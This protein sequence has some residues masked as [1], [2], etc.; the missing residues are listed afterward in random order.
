MK[1]K[2]LLL[3]SCALLLCGCGKIPTLSNGDE[4]VVTFK[5][6]A[7]ISANAL[8][9]EIKDNYGL[10]TLISMIDEYIYEKEFSDKMSD[11]EA[12]AKAVVSQ[13][14]SNYDDEASALQILQSYYGYSTF[15]AYQK[16]VYMNYLQSE[17]ITAYVKN[18]ITE[19]EL[20]EYYENDVYPSMTISHILVT[21]NVSSS[22][23]DD[24]KTEAE[25]AAKEKVK[26][27][28]S[29]LDTAKSEGKDIAEA[30]GSLAKEYSEDAESKNSN[31]ELGEINIGSLNSQY[32]ELVKAAAKLNDGEY[33]TDVITTELGYHVILKTK[34]GEK[35]SYEDSL[36]SMKDK[37]ADTKL[38]ASNSQ[39]LK[40]EAVKAYR[41]DYEL[42]IVDSELNSQYGKYM[43][44]L[45]NSAKSN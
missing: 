29:K 15:D 2:V 21:P 22:A 7:K 42:N 27:I 24:E 10:S 8:Y 11:A 14:K 31:G 44:N 45:I 4:A 13:F 35:V 39:E 28:I 5:D 25:N 34:T 38:S 26:E 9:E 43:N 36:D 23:T 37:I 3:G 41:D 12:Y 33:S 17:A 6:D 1:K 30:F 16:A 18:Q 19:D 32:D 20:K 40:V